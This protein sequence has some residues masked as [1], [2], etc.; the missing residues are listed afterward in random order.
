M[1]VE[2]RIRDA[3]GQLFDRYNLTADESFVSLYSCKL[4]L[5]VLSVGSG[6][7]LV[8]L[9][10]VSL[11]AA[12]CAAGRGSGNGGSRSE[13]EVG[14]SGATCVAALPG[15]SGALAFS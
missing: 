6:P 5:R 8:M 11:A 1:S 3:E 15:R 2:H 13:R 12:F 9:H 7:D 10:G 14:A 4:R